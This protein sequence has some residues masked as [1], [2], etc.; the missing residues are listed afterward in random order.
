VK[1]LLDRILLTLGYLSIMGVVMGMSA[2]TSISSSEDKSMNLLGCTPPLTLDT[3]GTNCVEYPTLQIKNYAAHWIDT[4][5]L[6]WQIDP[7]MVSEVRLHHSATAGIEADDT[8]NINGAAVVLTGIRLSAEQ[9]VIYPQFEGWS[10]FQGD[11]TSDEAKLILKDQMVLAAYNA[12]G[13]YLATNIQNAKVLDALYTSTYADAD[14]AN[15]GVYY[16]AGNLTTSVWAPTAQHVKL[17]IFDGNKNL[18]NTET[19][20][21][22]RATGIWSFTAP[23][24]NLDL[25]YYRFELTVFHP[26][27][28]AIEVIWSTDPYSVNLSTNGMY[29]Q[30]VN[31]NADALKPVGWDGHAVPTITDPEDAVIYEGHVRDFSVRDLSTSKANRGKFLAFTESS[32]V[33]LMH[34]KDLVGMGITHFHILPTFDI[35]SINEDATVTVNLDNTVADLCKLNAVALVCSVASNRVTLK[36]LLESYVPNSENA[37]ALVNTIRDYDSYNWGYDPKHYNAPDGSYSS[38]PEGTARISE[39]R[40]MIQALH[41][42]GLRVVLDSVY[43]HTNSSGLTDNSILDKIVPGYYH[44]RDLVTGKVQNST[45]CQDTALENRMMGKLMIDSLLFWTTNYAVDGFRFDLMSHGSVEQMLAARAEVQAVDPDNYFYGEGWSWEGD[46][47]GAN[48]ANQVNLAGSEIGTF[49]DRIRDVVRSAALFNG[50]ASVGSMQQ[51]D[52]VK[53]G[54]AGTL[55]NYI[56]VDA[57]GVATKGSSFYPSAYAKD[58]ADVINYVSKHDDETLWDKLQLNLNVVM[59]LENRVRSQNI[60]IAIPLMSQGIPFLQMG[61]D[62]LRSKS[63]DRN[64]FDSG[65]WFNYVDF[66]KTT[67][68]WNVGFPLAEGNTTNWDRINGLASSSLT[69]VVAK[70]VIFA[71]K[72]FKE[73]LSIRHNSKLFRLTT[74]ADV[75]ARVGF[76]NLGDTQKQ[77]VIVMSIDDGLDLV[78][79][80]PTNDAI[81]VMINGTDVTQSHAVPTATGFVL[82]PALSASVDTKMADANFTDS[83]FIVPS[84]TMAVFVKPQGSAQGD[85]LSAFASSEVPVPVPY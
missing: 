31:I 76:H 14:E 55:A 21:E 69:A 49:N 44:R 11:W 15:L 45:C 12:E 28:D 40:A 42:A 3:S 79:L 51:Q 85:G 43:N 24:I 54:M 20:V 46:G 50:D 38:N 26:Q 57:N 78:D 22:D 80:D 32:S 56:L 61:G 36:S 6:V 2:C 58:P 17:Q 75:L 41:T 4:N 72:I 16:D 53:L 84:K 62:L 67:N 27:N 60:A 82:H 52:I 19:M 59:S 13:A 48:R 35:A 77:G 39:M 65:D 66:T 83:S 73:F 68:N 47:S 30:F 37:Q 71:S 33:P 23:E 7:S 5:T 9:L 81:V 29:S 63:L 1:S 64:S 70:D 8:N 18:T 25:K 34:L 10:A 74:E